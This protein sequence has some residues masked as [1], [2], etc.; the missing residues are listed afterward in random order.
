MASKEFR[1]ELKIIAIGLL[2]VTVPFVV[3]DWVPIPDFVRGA[4]MGIGIALEII[5]LVR[6]NKR[7]KAGAA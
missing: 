4:L 7:K 1:P 2:L 5:G 3:N 6:M